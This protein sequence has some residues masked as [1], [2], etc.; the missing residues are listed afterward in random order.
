MGPVVS[1]DFGI[2]GALQAVQ[3]GHALDLGS[4]RQQALLARLLIARAVVSA[5]RLVDDLWA[6][7]A[8]DSA[9]HTLHVYVSRLRGALG[10]DGGRLERQGSG[11]RFR[12]E[13]VEL[14]ASRFEQLARAGREAR[15]GGDLE[16][17]SGRLSEAIDL[18]RGLALV[19][20]ADEPWAR[21]E[22]ARLEELRLTALEDRIWADLEMGHTTELVEAL[23]SLVSEHPFREAY[24]E[25]L[26]LA[27]YRSGRQADALRAYQV[28]RTKLSEELGIDPGPALQRMQ[29]RVVAQDPGLEHTADEPAANTPAGMPLQRTS[30]IGREQEVSD[31]SR[32]LMRSRLL[33]LTGPPGT[34]KTRLGLRLADRADGF[35]D[36]KAFVPLAPV[37]D[38]ALVSSAIARALDLRETGDEPV[39]DAVK[40]YLGEKRTLLL[41]DNFEHLLDAAPAIGELLDAAPDLK[42][43]ITSRSPLGISG[44]QEYPVPPLRVPPPDAGLDADQLRSSDAVA[45]FVARARA[46]VPN[47]EMDAADDSAVAEITR[48][49]DGLPL[50]IE[51]AAARVR[52][53]SPADLLERLERR[54]D[55]LAAGP[56]DVEERHRTMRGAVAW[57]H[58]LLEPDEQA[59]FRRLAVFRG[60]FTLAAA[61]DV[62]GHPTAET[63]IGVE[64][65]LAQS[66]LYRPVSTGQ[67]RY[68]MLETMRA[69]ALERLTSADEDSDT[70]A[71]HASFYARLT[72]SIEPEFSGED[73][74]AAVER[75]AVEVDNLRAALGHAISTAAADTGLG[76]AGGTWR[77]WQSTGQLREGRSWL[78]RTLALEGASPAAR[79]KGLDARAGL[80]YWLGEFE[81]AQRDY[82]EAHDLYLAAGDRLAAATTDYCLSLVASFLD[83]ADHAEQLAREARL[84]FEELG[85]EAQIA[86]ALMAE[87]TATWKHGDLARAH[88]LTQQSLVLHRRLK[89]Q[90]MIASQLVGL[91]GIAYQLGQ[92]DEAILD[93]TRALDLAVEIDNAH[94]QIF[95][96]DALASFIARDRPTEAATLAGAA[97][98]L[99]ESHGGGW[100]LEPFGIENARAAVSTS[101][102]EDDIERVWS[103]GSELSLDQAVELGRRLLVQS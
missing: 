8:P 51:L 78:D 91:S 97:S 65:L 95:A 47:F 28:Q 85:S 80:S 17:A 29:E 52:L 59:L 61:A 100:T 54:F 86:Q 15:A 88:Q 23:E 79:A 81:T 92:R 72:S 20:F 33:T 18:W 67:A 83:K 13:P 74:G 69:Y 48:R 32:A 55:V 87:G 39:I 41:L 5:D 90:S 53:F 71:R 43:V 62:A 31:A 56:A 103:E 57:S 77:F 82:A 76:L 16:T 94:I 63:E 30:F 49:L 24:V 73:P 1:T 75:L 40:A 9:R 19:D 44:E 38:P 99:R 66:L 45:L 14:D 50:A 26:M 98:A 27:L 84:V 25:Q 7:D 60:G 22:S 102:A 37:N 34:G 70:A 3:D 58:D 89:D 36:G 93:V 2:L 35:P 42:V 64:S 6:A 11:Y 96:L 46:T 101:L 68:T 12:V 21:E 10:P 4:P